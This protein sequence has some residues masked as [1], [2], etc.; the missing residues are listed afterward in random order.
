[1]FVSQP[2]LEPVPQLGLWRSLAL[3]VIYVNSL[4]GDRLHIPYPFYSDLASV[5]NWAWPFLVCTPNH[6]SVAG[7]VHDYLCRTDAKLITHDGYEES[8]TF[9]RS[10]MIM[11]SVMVWSRVSEIDRWKVISALKHKPED[12]WHL[13]P[14]SW[15][16]AGL[17]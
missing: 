13:K 11:N 12:Y 17:N 16:P 9:D 7:Y 1:M 15:R 6:L 8:I 10:L 2:K 14:V 5:P 3:V 4:K